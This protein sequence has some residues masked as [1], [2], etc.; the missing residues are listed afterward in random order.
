MLVVHLYIDVVC[1]IFGSM[2]EFGRLAGDEVGSLAW[3]FTAGSIPDIKHIVTTVSLTEQSLGNILR[4]PLSVM[5]QGDIRSQ[6][7]LN[8]VMS[9]DPHQQ[10][11]WKGPKTPPRIKTSILAGRSP[12][13]HPLTRLIGQLTGIAQT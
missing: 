10:S 7:E 13:H 4:S 2:Q 5:V 1:V 8:D 12:S 3:N 6:K 11:M 9:R